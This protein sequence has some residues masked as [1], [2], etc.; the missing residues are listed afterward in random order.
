MLLVLNCRSFILHIALLVNNSIYVVSALARLPNTIELRS[1]DWLWH[2]EFVFHFDIGFL[3]L[4]VQLRSSVLW[5]RNV[6][7]NHGAFSWRYLDG[8]LTWCLSI[9]HLPSLHLLW[10]ARIMTRSTAAHAQEALLSEIL[11]NCP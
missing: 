9:H 2:F 7:D 4:L 6:P 5:R 1:F 11:I 3:G 8:V 10:L